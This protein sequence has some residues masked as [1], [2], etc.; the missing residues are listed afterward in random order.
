MGVYMSQA[1][2]RSPEIAGLPETVYNA[3]MDQSSAFDQ[4]ARALSTEERQRL[5]ERIESAFAEPNEPLAG[6]RSDDS[7][8]TEVEWELQRLNLLQRMFLALIA[9]FTNRSKPSIMKDILLRRLRNRIV[10]RYGGLIDFRSSFFTE[11]MYGE[12]SALS[13][14]VHFFGAPLRQ[15]L[16]YSKPDFFAF[17]VGMELPDVGTRLEEEI[18][19]VF[20]RS[21]DSLAVSDIS[22]KD[23]IADFGA[24]AEGMRPEE[25]RI[26][27]DDAQALYTLSRLLQCPF[28]EVLSSFRED[29][30]TGAHECE[31][32]S[33]R[34]ALIRIC[35]SLC[36]A[37]YAPSSTALHSLFLFTFRE[38][39]DEE[40][41]DLEESLRTALEQ[42]HGALETIRSFNERV[43]LVLIIRYI[44]QDLSFKPKKIGGGEDWF[45]SFKEFWVRRIETTFNRLNLWKK[46]RQIA[47][48]AARYLD[49]RELKGFSRL[50]PAMDGDRAR[51]RFDLTLAFL[52]HF[53]THVFKKV[54]RSLDFISMSGEFYKEQNRKEFMDAVDYLS[55]LREKLEYMQNRLSEGGD[56]YLKVAGIEDDDV[57]A[58]GKE[59]RIAELL[60]EFDEQSLT[61]IEKAV[62]AVNS[63]ILLLGGILHGEPGAR[64]DTISNFNSIGGRNNRYLIASWERALEYF[65]QAL[66]FLVD[67]KDLES[68]AG[69]ADVPAFNAS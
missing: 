42:A 8:G 64:Y 30:E 65:N 32:Q 17:L 67:L 3:C 37:E 34:A 33:T 5:L 49:L 6:G 53:V 46:T 28:A 39:L 13:N 50:G 23:V 66:G 52:H 45:V 14:S 1:A 12:L 60:S 61:V 47:E 56:L 57:N 9:F 48:S 16:G 55:N 35:E 29:P 62:Q 18:D 40:E 63:S 27:Y 25:K 24:I 22:K 41:F 68:K 19:S 2:V 51:I 31:F 21:M 11:K 43:P 7:E 20:Q 69:T 36:S 58:K 26:V 44:T 54:H 15:A 38:R 4:L 10:N 59:K